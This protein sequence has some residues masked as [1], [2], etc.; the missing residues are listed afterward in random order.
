MYVA[1]RPSYTIVLLYAP[2]DSNKKNVERALKSRDVCIWVVIFYEWGY[3]IC[4]RWR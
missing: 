2:S 1:I 3:F 4:V